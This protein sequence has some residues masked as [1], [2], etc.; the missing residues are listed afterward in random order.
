M[1]NQERIDCERRYL[2]LI[3]GDLLSAN[4]D[5]EKIDAVKP[6]PR[7]KELVKIHGEVM[8]VHR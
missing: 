7:Y 2:S 1:S 6:H 8:Y 3:V 4:S 5:Q